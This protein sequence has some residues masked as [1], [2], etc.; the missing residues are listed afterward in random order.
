MAFQNSLPLFFFIL[1]VFVCS[2]DAYKF[3]VG[4]KDGWVLSPKEEYSHWAGRNRF[5]INDVLFF[6][7][8]N[9][10]DSVLV[11]NKDDYDKCNTQNPIMKLE[12]GDSVFT[13]DRSG[14]FYFISGNKEYCDKGQKLIVVVLST[15]HF[16]PQP[17]S[18]SP[19]PSPSSPAPTPVSH[20]PATSPV[21]A[22]TPSGSPAKAPTPSSVSP[23]PTP[24][25]S[26]AKAPTP[27]AVS[28]VPT[29]SR[30]PAK[31]PT[32]SAVSPVSPAT[33]TA[34]PE[35]SPAVPPVSPAPGSP[36]DADVAA[37]APAPSPSAASIGNLPWASLAL[38]VAALASVI[39]VY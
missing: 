22:P 19:K 32:P 18:V 37:P 31:A 23:V 35:K 9:G 3:Y 36:P 29:P 5:L 39:V 16:K 17:P 33:P 38:S 28:P 14:P 15:A 11:V 2:S 10:T 24:Y 6:K 21:L 20:S 7:Y 8:K 26:P 1:T 4:G 13:L 25:R 30:S 12:G 27:S 34:T